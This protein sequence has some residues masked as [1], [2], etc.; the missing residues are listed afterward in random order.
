VKVVA[1]IEIDSDKN[2]GRVAI[3]N[4]GKLIDEYHLDASLAVTTVKAI[5]AALTALRATR[6]G[7]RR[8]R[9]F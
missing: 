2:T 9:R 8:S 3:H 7:D 5:T 4:D 1:T 6:A